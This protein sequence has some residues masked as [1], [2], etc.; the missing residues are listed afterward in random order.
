MYSFLIKIKNFKILIEFAIVIKIKNSNW[1]VFQSRKI[2]FA[3]NYTILITKIKDSRCIYNIT[4]YNTMYTN[5]SIRPLSRHDYRY[6]TH[7][8][9]R[10]AAENWQQFWNGNTKMKSWRHAKDERAM[11]WGIIYVD[12]FTHKMGTL[13]L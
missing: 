7:S 10:T 8:L 12:N 9:R 5:N 3:V 1:F 13:K 11:N 2:A 6:L 4:K